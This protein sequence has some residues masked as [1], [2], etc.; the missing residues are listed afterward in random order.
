MGIDGSQYK[1]K[2]LKQEHEQKERQIRQEIFTPK[3]N[4]LF[5]NRYNILFSGLFFTLAILAILGYLFLP[6]SLSS[7]ELAQL[8]GRCGPSYFPACVITVH[9]GLYGRTLKNVSILIENKKSHSRTTYSIDVDI[10]PETAKQSKFT[11]TLM[12]EEEF[13]WSFVSARSVPSM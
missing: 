11:C 13:S 1:Q 5:E 10:P 3:T 7:V 2:K 9:N 6:R 8:D 12:E 4:Y